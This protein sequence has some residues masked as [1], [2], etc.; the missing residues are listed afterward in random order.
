MSSIA[1]RFPLHGLR[2]L[3]LNWCYQKTYPLYGRL[4]H[5]GRPCWQVRQ[6]ALARMPPASLGAQL[7]YFLQSNQLQLMP[8]FE[9]HDVFHTLLDY[10][11]SA[12]QEVALQWCLIG[13]GKR[14]GYAI[15]T[16]LIGLLFFPEHWGQMRT[17]YQRGKQ[18][19]RFHHWYFEYL[20]SENLQELKAFLNYQK[21]SGYVA[22]Y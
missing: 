2:S 16:A 15:I 11:T 12:P 7:G 9:N 10:D 8:G 13:N 1:I 19:R 14:S 17:A 21:T 22:K 18:M 4:T 20:L 5:R 3:I 6:S